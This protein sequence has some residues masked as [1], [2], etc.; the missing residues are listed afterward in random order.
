MPNHIQLP[1]Y[2]R[3]LKQTIEK[4]IGNVKRFMAYGIV[5]ILNLEEKIYS[6]EIKVF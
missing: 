2:T 4:I 1:V 6:A 5:K 3:N